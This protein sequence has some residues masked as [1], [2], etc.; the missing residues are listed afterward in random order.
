MIDEQLSAFLKALASETRQQILFQ[1]VDGRPR[2]VSEVA[3]AAG[4]VISTVSE[5]LSQMRRAG[6]VQATREGKEVYYCPDAAR[7]RHALAQLTQLL[8]RFC[9]SVAG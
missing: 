1:F 7:I 4:L 6:I 3:Q 2:T 8:D 5:H 9:A